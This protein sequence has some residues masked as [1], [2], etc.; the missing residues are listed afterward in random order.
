MYR[1]L[2]AATLVVLATSGCATLFGSQ[3]KTIAM[4][5]NPNEAEVW[6][7]GVRRGTTPVSIQL[8]QRNSHI[9]TFRKEGHD[10]VV[11]EL[12]TT[13]D[14]K[15]VILDVLGGLLPVIV[16]AATGAWRSI[17][18]GTCNMVLPTIRGDDWFAMSG[19]QYPAPH[20]GWR[21]VESR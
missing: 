12:A 18:R 19:E 20:L 17:D 4:S 6:I 5:S 15:W 14:A 13:V 1:H 8:D 7:D 21:V 9:V 11:C 2:L 3:F 16:D 10:D